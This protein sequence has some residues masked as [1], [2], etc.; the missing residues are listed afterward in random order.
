MTIKRLAWI[1]GAALLS[2]VLNIVLSILY[3]AF[4]SYFINLGHDQRFYEE[5]ANV[6]APYC[7]IIFGIPVLYFVGRWIGGKWERNFA[8]KAAVLVWLVYALIDLSVLTAAGWTIQLAVIS[9]ISMTTK[10]IAAY[11]G[12]KAAGRRIN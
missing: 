11:F 3:V 2:M 5:Y 7:S 1:I 12:G 8:V 10:L 6:A 9:V 4:Y